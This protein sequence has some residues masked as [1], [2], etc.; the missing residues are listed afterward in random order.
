[1]S[2]FQNMKHKEI[3]E[4]LQISPKTVETQ[5]YRSLS[6]LREKLKHNQE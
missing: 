3:A 2:R 6:F 4:A 1:M 5:I